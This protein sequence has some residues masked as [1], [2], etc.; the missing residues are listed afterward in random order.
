MALAHF[1]VNNFIKIE[2]D[3]V[4]IESRF[5]IC[6]ECG[7]ILFA[8]TLLNGR[9]AAEI[10]FSVGAVIAPLGGTM[11]VR[12]GQSS[13][14]IWLLIGDQLN[15]PADWTRFLPC[16]GA[17]SER[18]KFDVAVKQSS[19]KLSFKL[20][21]NKTLMVSGKSVYE[22]DWRIADDQILEHA[23]EIADIFGVELMLGDAD[24]YIR[25]VA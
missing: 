11:I 15:D 23:M 12:I 7:A 25:S 18:F 17:D 22:Y 8:R 24:Q 16:H 5:S 9:V 13:T 4:K 20:N 19:G 3:L 21:A 14:G 6:T 1:Q 2:L 10:C